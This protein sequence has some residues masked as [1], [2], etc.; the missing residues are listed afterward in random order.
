MAVL[1]S[2]AFLAASCT[3][4][5]GEGDSEGEGPRSSPT[6]YAEGDTLDAIKAPALEAWLAHY[7]STDTAFRRN[8]FLASG[9]NL[10]ID[11][12]EACPY[13]DTGTLQLLA[14]V[15]AWSPDSSLA[16]D[17][18]SYDH[19]IR[20]DAK[21]RTLLEGG[22]PDQMVKLLDRRSATARQLLFSGP[23][24][25]VETADW[26]SDKAFVMGLLNIDEAT[27]EAIPDIILINLTDS[28]FTNFRYAG[29]NLPAEG[30]F[31]PAWLRSKGIRYE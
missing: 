30:G 10:R 27:G 4:R 21:N 13:P 12:L 3:H 22:G 31:M 23:S 25:V 19:L 26:V 16:I 7:Q 20:R 18:W 6:S 28:V 29:R 5:H 9:I 1:W 15:L 8:A 14:P 11:S 24:Q 2:L 17:I